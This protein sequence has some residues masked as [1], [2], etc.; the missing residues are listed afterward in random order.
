MALA[1][2]LP[3]INIDDSANNLLNIPPDTNLPTRA[4]RGSCKLPPQPVTISH[5][6]LQDLLPLQGAASASDES[7][8][9]I[10]LITKQNNCLNKARQRRVR[11]HREVIDESDPEVNISCHP[12]LAHTGNARSWSSHVAELENN[13]PQIKKR[14]HHLGKGPHKDAMTFIPPHL[15]KKE[16]KSASQPVMA[17]TQ[18]QYLPP[19]LRKIKSPEY[20]QAVHHDIPVSPPTQTEA[21]SSS[22]GKSAS[23]ETS[24]KSSKWAQYTPLLLNQPGCADLQYSSQSPLRA[25]EGPFKLMT[26]TD[27]APKYARFDAKPTSDDFNGV[28]P[29]KQQ[30]LDSESNPQGGQALFA[31]QSTSTASII[32]SSLKSELKAPK[33]AAT[34]VTSDTPPTVKGANR[35]KSKTFSPEPKSSPGGDYQCKDSLSSVRLRPPKSPGGWLTE[36]ERK[37]M[38]PQEV[39]PCVDTEH[40]D[41]DLDEEDNWDSNNVKNLVDWD[42]NWLP[43]PVEWEGRANYKRTNFYANVLEWAKVTN[44]FYL[45]QHN[46]ED[47]KVVVDITDERYSNSLEFV[48][49]AWVPDIIDNQTLQT[50]WHDLQ[51][52]DFKAIDDGDLKDPPFWHR[53]SGNDSSFQVRH[54]VPDAFLDPTDEQVEEGMY[55][56]GK[57]E[58]CTAL[59]LI[60]EHKRKA[61]MGSKQR[62]KAG[63]LERLARKKAAM[64]PV[65]LPPPNPNRPKVNIFLRPFK[66][67]DIVQMTDIYN[68]FVTNT[69]HV[70]DRIRRTA[71]QMRSYID[72]STG[73]SLP[74]IVAVEKTSNNKRHDHCVTDLQA[75]QEKIIGFASAEDWE[76]MHSMYRYAVEVEVHVHADYLGKGVGKSLLDRMMFL[77]DPSYTSR[78]AV[79]WRL[80]ENDPLTLRYAGGARVI[81]TV[82]ALVDFAS[83][84][85]SR[86]I[87]INRWLEQ[88]GF[89]KKCELDNSGYKLGKMYVLTNK[90]TQ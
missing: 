42:G 36:A 85:R 84:D 4:P 34:A 54:V 20:L 32:K 52:S 72:Y 77:L 1:N 38:R 24:L 28:L 62:M 26:S 44:M 51:Q 6:N 48:P 74:A 81:G 86:T 49:R 5:S 15:K 13:S 25:H 31:T 57:S 58:G 3:L 41:V 66:A 75:T 45:C 46:P 19:H 11:A 10:A 71:S 87:W 2:T 14:N 33:T 7:T 68:H 56:K 64:E 88:F 63:K 39:L 70:S 22:S 27:S 30:S 89:T 9:S 69:C 61:N 17:P 21:I 50:Y 37:S 78:D 53:F 35:E 47:P 18:P 83:G 67:F 59:E 12:L 16:P 65:I 76:N 73:N 23:E 60:K 29:H 40:G 79:E 80:E 82:F 8:A 90:D 55:Q 43:A